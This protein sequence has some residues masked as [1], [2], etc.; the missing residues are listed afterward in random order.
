MPTTMDFH[1]LGWNFRDPGAVP[2]STPD[3]LPLLRVEIHRD[4]NHRSTPTREG[5][6]R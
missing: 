6:S 5:R 3:G 1:S 4:G 2:R